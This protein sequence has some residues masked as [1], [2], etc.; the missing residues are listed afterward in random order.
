M[1]IGAINK[2]VGAILLQ[3][4]AKINPLVLG[5]LILL[6]D[7]AMKL[8]AGHGILGMVEAILHVLIMQLVMV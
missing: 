5:K 4:H 1:A 8:I 3:Q 7:G 2:I 6:L